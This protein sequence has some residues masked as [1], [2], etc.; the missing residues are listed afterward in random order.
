MDII[1]KDQEY[2]CFI[3][4]KYRVDTR[5][6]RPEVAVNYTKQ[7]KISRVAD[8]YMVKHQMSQSTDVRFDVVAIL[9]DQCYLYKNAFSYI[10]I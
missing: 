5:A 8:Y 9:S 1:A 4:V 3:E 7:K 10:P 6:G 2:L